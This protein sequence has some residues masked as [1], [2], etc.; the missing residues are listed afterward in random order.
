MRRAGLKEEGNQ[1]EG[2]VQ[3][4]REKNPGIRRTSATR[5]KHRIQLAVHG[6]T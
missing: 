5:Q 4:R 6:P 2:R 3:E 1:E